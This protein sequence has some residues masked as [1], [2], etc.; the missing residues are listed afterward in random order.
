MARLHPFTSWIKTTF[1]GKYL[2]ATPEDKSGIGTVMRFRD[3][4]IA[5]RVEDI[6]KGTTGGRID[7]LQT[8]VIARQL[9][10]ALS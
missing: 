1:L 9:A 4:V 3:K 5:E 7:L 2:I 10:K 8:Y 6:K